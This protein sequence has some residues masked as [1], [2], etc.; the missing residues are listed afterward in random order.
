[1]HE[2]MDVGVVDIDGAG[3]F[4]LLELAGS[5]DVVGEDCADLVEVAEVEE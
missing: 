2:D 1:M 4:T 5:E 3:E